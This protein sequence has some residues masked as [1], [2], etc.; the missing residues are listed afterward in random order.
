MKKRLVAIMVAVFVMLTNSVYAWV[1]IEKKSEESSM[2][3]PD[4]AVF[5]ETYG[6]YIFAANWSDV[7]VYRKDNI[8]KIEKEINL[9]DV[10]GLLISRDYLIVVQKNSTKIYDITSLY[11]STEPI[12]TL[13]YG[14]RK[15]KGYG[16]ND[17]CL[18]L[19]TESGVKVF[20]I[21][22]VLNIKEV[23]V[24]SFTSSK[25]FVDGG[26]MFAVADE[27][28]EIYSIQELKNGNASVISS[29][30][31][32][33]PQNEYDIV[34]SNG[35]MFVSTDNTSSTYGNA[36]FAYEIES[37][38]ELGKYVVR[39]NNIGTRVMGL[40]AVNDIL[41]VSSQAER[42]IK[43][44]DVSLP[45]NMQTLATVAIDDT[46]Y[47]Y[48]F[49]YE[50]NSL[51]VTGNDSKIKVY[52]VMPTYITELEIYN[53]KS[54]VG[55]LVENEEYR[56][57]IKIEN[58]TE[59]DI[60]GVL[61][62]VVYR[63]NR[64][65]GLK[66]TDVVALKGSGKTEFYTEAV[67]C[68]SG[69]TIKLM[70]WDSFSTLVPLKEYTVADT[71]DKNVVYDIY[72]DSSNSGGDGTQGDPYA[73]L[74]EA[75]DAVRS[76]NRYAEGDITIHIKGGKY[77]LESSFML[78]EDDSGYNGNK[79][80]YKAEDYNNKPVLDGGKEISDWKDA[81]NG[82]YKAK[83]TG[84]SNRQ[85]Y[86]NGKQAVRAK[87]A[88]G[89]IIGFTKEETG[90]SCQ[91]TEFLNYDDITDLE[92]VFKTVWVSKRVHPVSI[93]DRGDGTVFL[94][95]KDWD[96]L[97]SG[98]TQL[99]PTRVY[100]YENALDLLDDEGEFYI[101]GGFVY[102]KPFADEP[103]DDSYITASSL[104]GLMNLKG[105]SSVD[106]A[107][108]IV[109][110]GIEFA[111][112]S[113][114]EPSE[115]G[116]FLGNQNLSNETPTP[117]VSVDNAENI[118]FRN[119]EFYCSGGDGIFFSNS[120][121]DIV[122][123]GNEISE[124]SARG[125]VIGNTEIA[126]DSNDMLVVPERFNINN[127]SIHNIGCQYYGATAITSV[128]AKN[129]SVT[130]NE[131]YDIPYSGTH[132]GW[133]WSF[134][135]KTNTENID[136][137]HNYIHDFMQTMIDGGA[138]Y[139]L[140]ST[141]GDADNMSVASY[142]YIQNGGHGKNI[143]C[144]EGSE[145]YEIHHNVVDNSEYDEN[146][147]YIGGVGGSGTNK[148][149]ENYATTDKKSGSVESEYIF[150]NGNFPP[151]AREIIANSGIEAEYAHLRS[152]YKKP[153]EN[154]YDSIATELSSGIVIEAGGKVFVQKTDSELRQYDLELKSYTNACIS[155]TGVI[156]DAKCCGDKLVIGYSDGSKRYISVFNSSLELI[157]AVE[158][159][160]EKFS[161]DVYEGKVYCLTNSGL[162]TYQIGDSSVDLLNTYASI[163]GNAV[164]VN[165]KGVFVESSGVIS[166]YSLNETQKCL[167]KIDGQAD[168]SLKNKAVSFMV[169][170][171]KNNSVEYTKMA[172]ADSSGSFAFKARV[173]YDE[174]LVIKIN[175]DGTYYEKAINCG[176]DMS[177]NIT[178]SV[179]L[180][181]DTNVAVAS[182]LGIVD[183][184]EYGVRSFDLIDD[185]LKVHTMFPC[186]KNGNLAEFDLN[187]LENGSYTALNIEN[188]I[189]YK[190]VIN[191][192]NSRNT[193]RLVASSDEYKFVAAGT[194]ITVTDVVTGETITTISRTI[195]ATNST[196][197][198]IK[199][200]A[201]CGDTLV[202][203][204]IQNGGLGNTGFSFYDVANIEKDAMLEPV[205][206]MGTNVSNS[207]D[208]VTGGGY[209]FVSTAHGEKTYV[210]EKASDGSYANIGTISDYSDKM[211]FADDVLYLQKSDGI[212]MYDMFAPKAY[213]DGCKLSEIPLT[214][215]EIET[216]A[217]GCYDGRRRLTMHEG[218][219]YVLNESKG[220][221]LTGSE[222]IYRTYEEECR[223]NIFCVGMHMFIWE[224]GHG[225]NVLKMSEI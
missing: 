139:F 15:S 222:R 53:D 149:V 154:V 115:K 190:D 36:V 42:S 112:T 44:V 34:T 125:I 213:M 96:K 83:A 225:I 105:D 211:Y 19:N 67:K 170:N 151:E 14:A 181:G 204:Y 18:I 141:D 162:K 56:G 191:H 169:Y 57:S 22:D 143:Y 185:R 102:Y 195:N 51:Y 76:F 77:N 6:D 219:Q 41:F 11:E 82:I 94:E 124:I 43:M 111:Y 49:K 118:E 157:E 113:Y 205:D 74:E 208:V 214:L 175:A 133:G 217:V 221:V 55:T 21:S 159:A 134:Y 119:C 12:Y 188:P 200:V 80:I 58:Y 104:E 106:R 224:S 4:G 177:E 144:D 129:V 5:I 212:H 60:Q 178:L 79:I 59:N 7:Y 201:V 186:S 198:K 164:N 20:D 167:I 160:S 158:V 173:P 182:V 92:F 166:S 90:F 8:D 142:N 78:T 121:D 218:V 117:M 84:I 109:F 29:V 153:F 62:L 81:G 123:E 209:I 183:L 50:N 65:E 110:D 89:T 135:E 136:I 184:S 116:S 45:E 189:D 28:I 196:K 216:L 61:L 98:N 47:G 85:L 93:T 52:D 108:N 203:Y 26:Y 172:T 31:R 39:I 48:N 97:N 187:S 126:Y 16:V 120:T 150:K 101:G 131:I 128:W 68:V 33:T 72:V 17:D 40:Q 86:V 13:N 193:D 137:S 165:D 199:S 194:D 103:I 161:F 91:N 140:G 127:N 100:H 197:F 25:I 147:T 155:V 145:Y 107:E 99:I 1:D 66:K 64:L 207:G 163:K 69:D 23:S 152:G 88:E 114:D 87:S 71:F 202:V 223:A 206:G 168:S 148:A 132:F 32:P 220:G 130:H 138:I 156:S 75:R 192:I 10:Q 9:G 122:F 179:K 3:V 174:D 2:N 210:F 70:F 37:G 171:N 180:E 63:N 215:A 54:K 30:T 176:E 146:T 27:K 35:K 95:I 38:N 46:A 73:S 24:G